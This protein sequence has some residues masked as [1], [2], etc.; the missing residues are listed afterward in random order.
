MAGKLKFIYSW[1]HSHQRYKS[2]TSFSGFYSKNAAFS[3]VI[4]ESDGWG[5]GS[6]HN[7]GVGVGLRGYGMCQ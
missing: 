5:F 7:F 4:L 6:C 1:F 3:V 2:M